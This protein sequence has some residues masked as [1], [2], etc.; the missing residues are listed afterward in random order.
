MSLRFKVGDLARMKYIREANGNSTWRAGL[1]VEITAIRTPRAVDVGSDYEVTYP[2]QPASR[3][4]AARDDQLEPLP[5]DSSSR[6]TDTGE[7]DPAWKRMRESL[8]AAADVRREKQKETN[9][10]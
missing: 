8:Q 6:S 9:H 5:G 2:E 4:S 7:L 3:W 1:I 10:A